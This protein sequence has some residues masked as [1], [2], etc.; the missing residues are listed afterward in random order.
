MRRN[1][2][3]QLH[4]LLAM[5]GKCGSLLFGILASAEPYVACLFA[6][7]RGT[8]RKGK[9]L[10]FFFVVILSSKY[11]QSL[12]SFSLRALSNFG[13]APMR[14]AWSQ[15]TGPASPMRSWGPS[16]P[17]GNIPQGRVAI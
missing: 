9:G 12:D 7:A 11:G 10:Y 2:V 8:F 13:A 16:A 6:G 1:S 5:S 17:F 3:N 14:A 4:L 15:S